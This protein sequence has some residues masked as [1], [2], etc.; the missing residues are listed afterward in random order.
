[1]AEK[2]STKEVL[3]V[4]PQHPQLEI[5]VVPLGT[6]TPDGLKIKAVKHHFRQFRGGGYLKTSDPALIE[7]IRTDDLYISKK[8]FESEIGDEELKQARAGV[9]VHAGAQGVAPVVPAPD[10]QDGRKRP[11]AAA[12]TP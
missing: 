2:T 3:F 7:R 6:A 10:S 4:C 1:M 12:K 8:I 5:V 11:V 9:A